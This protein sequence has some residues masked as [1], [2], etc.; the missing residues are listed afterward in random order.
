MQATAGQLP[1]RV[2]PEDDGRSPPAPAEPLG[3]RYGAPRPHVLY[4]PPGAHVLDGT[5][6]PAVDGPGGSD[7]RVAHGLT[8]GSRGNPVDVGPA[9][10]CWW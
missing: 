4:G 5:A 8:T 2:G 3:G 1:D 9:A 6:D 10:H 7:G